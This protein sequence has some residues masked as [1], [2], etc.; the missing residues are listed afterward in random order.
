MLV[1]YYKISLKEFKMYSECDLNKKEL[2]KSNHLK[3]QVDLLH[4][5]KRKKGNL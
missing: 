4:Y 1:K 5:E 3:K 2:R